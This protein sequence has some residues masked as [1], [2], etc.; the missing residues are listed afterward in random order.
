[1]T[2]YVFKKPTGFGY[3]YDQREP[4]LFMSDYEFLYET[5]EEPNIDGKIWDGTKW[6]SGQTTPQYIYDRLKNYPSLGSQ[7]DMFWH[8]MD[9]GVIP[10]I[11][12]F[13]TDIKTVKE[14]YPKT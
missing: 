8:A 3:I 6:I 13:Y 5:E 2:Y 12:P 1:M 14:T 7:M 4:N 10:K 9:D 11:E